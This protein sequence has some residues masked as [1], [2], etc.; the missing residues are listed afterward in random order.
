ML[1]ILSEPD[2][3]YYELQTVKNTEDHRCLRPSSCNC[4]KSKGLFRQSILWSIF[5]DFQHCINNYIHRLDGFFLKDSY[6][7]RLP[8]HQ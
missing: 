1:K 7:Y 6:A 8:L 4:N 2:L 3:R 5:Q